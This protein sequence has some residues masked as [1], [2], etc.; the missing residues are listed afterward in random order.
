MKIFVI[1]LLFFIS[2]KVDAQMLASVYFKNNSYEIN[3]ESK[4]KLDSLSQLKSNLTFRIFGNCDPSGNI[5]LNKKLS[6]NRANAVSEYLKNKIGSNIKLGNAVGL[7][8]EKQINDNSTEELRE[9][10]RRVDI[11]IEKAF[12]KGE[13]ISRKI[14]PSFLSTKIAQMKVK[15]TFSLPDVNFIG[16]RHVWLPSGNYNLLRLL[17]ILKENPSLE[18]EL[19]G[20]ICCDYDNFDGED[21]DLGTFNLSW[22]RANAIKEFLLKQGIES[23]RIKVSGLGHL[24]P[25]IYPE[26]TES[27]RMKNRRVELVLLKK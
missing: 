7:G 27:D 22:T 3:K 24:N 18:V 14:L 25:V 21:A 5:E 9:K 4:T 15:D 19:Q 17:K 6:E 26:I 23:T 11:F 12:A 16:G 1:I 20:H 10:N 2:I 8:V 13:K